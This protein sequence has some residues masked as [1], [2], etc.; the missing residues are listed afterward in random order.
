MPALI[1]FVRSRKW[2]GNMIRAHRTDA[3]Q[4][5]HFFRYTFSPTFSSR[6]G[7]AT[8]PSVEA[9]MMVFPEA[10]GPNSFER[11]TLI[12][13]IVPSTFISTFFIIHSLSTPAG[14]E[15]VVCEKSCVVA[16]RGI[17]HRLDGG[18]SHR[19]SHNR[20]HLNNSQRKRDENGCRHLLFIR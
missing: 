8:F 17:L 4:G 3:S 6:F 11:S 10:D 20:R 16:R 2:H 14:V 13:N 18:C 15:I 9:M 1:P 12:V 7:I 19:A 5:V